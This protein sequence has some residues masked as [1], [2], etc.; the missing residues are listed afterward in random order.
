MEGDSGSIMNPL[1]R[2]ILNN[3]LS[4]VLTQCNHCSVSETSSLQNLLFL[5]ERQ[6]EMAADYFLRKNKSET[7]FLSYVQCLQCL[8]GML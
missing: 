2:R 6:L 1:H 4:I 3:R 7:Y 8:S 5:K